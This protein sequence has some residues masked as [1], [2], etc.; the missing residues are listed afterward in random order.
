MS[1]VRIDLNNPDRLLWQ[2][3]SG[4]VDEA[5]AS[6]DGARHHLDVFQSYALHPEERAAWYECLKLIIEKKVPFLSSGRL[7]LTRSIIDFHLD[8]TPE[9]SR[10][11]LRLYGETG[12][13]H[14]KELLPNGVMPLAA[15]VH[16][17]NALAVEL[18]LNL[19]APEEICFHGEPPRH[20]YEYALERG[21]ARVLSFLAERAMRNALSETAAAA[22]EAA[23]RINRRMGL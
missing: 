18:L 20:V 19:G 3:K 5:L 8:S 7:S 23:S 17:N 11:L 2:L 1:D 16:E 15:A 9:M 4:K 14:A 12:G 22:T 13:V 21:A 10:A 6:L